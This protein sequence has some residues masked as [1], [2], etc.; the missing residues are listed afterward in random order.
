MRRFED[1]KQEVILTYKK[2]RDEGKLPHNLQYFTPA[3]LKKECLVVFPDRYAKNDEET[4]KSL[5]N[6]KRNSAEEY[7]KEVTESNP[8]IFKP[9]CNF[10]KG[11]TVNTQERN[12]SPKGTV[13]TQ[14]RNIELLAWLIDFQPRPHLPADMSQVVKSEWESSVNKEEEPAKKEPEENKTVDI[15]EE[16]KEEFSESAST[17]TVNGF[18][19]NRSLDNDQKTGNGKFGFPRKFNKA[20]I[21]FFAAFI[22]VGGSYF[23]YDKSSQCMYWNGN[24]Y[25]TVACDQKIEGANILPKDNFRLK[26]LKRIKNVSEITRGDIGK[27]YY[28]KVNRKVEF[29]TT[30]GVDVDTS[31]IENPTDSRKRLLP[32]T[33]HMYTEYVE[34]KQP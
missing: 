16:T 9:L 23:F 8:D 15:V 34:S 11:G 1:Y 17:L 30:G 33:E 18:L 28:S 2:R 3:N 26:Q 13:T 31:G 12:I 5:L 29:Y 20:V 32:L 24:E 22:I 7:L 27:I 4:F 10:L 6:V 14:E 21:S 25:Q 19:D